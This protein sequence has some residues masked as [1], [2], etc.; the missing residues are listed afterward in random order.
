M[1]IFCV[2]FSCQFLVKSAKIWPQ[3]FF[4]CGPFWAFWPE[5]LPPGNTGQ[6][7]TYQS[8]TVSFSSPPSPPVCVWC[9][10]CSV[11]AGMANRSYSWPEDLICSMPAGPVRQ[12]EPAPIG[13]LPSASPIGGERSDVS[14]LNSY[15][16]WCHAG[17]AAGHTHH[18]QTHQYRSYSWDSGNTS[19]KMPGSVL[20]F[21]AADCIPIVG[22]VKSLVLNDKRFNHTKV[23]CTFIFIDLQA[24]KS[25]LKVHKCQQIYGKM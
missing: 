16:V 20:W 22:S 4:F 1:K 3:F 15:V 8:S 9:V 2:P 19:V 21:A 6:H 25:K 17:T 7:H 5:F 18:T 14:T 10:S 24:R 11:L 12:G 23:W 13:R